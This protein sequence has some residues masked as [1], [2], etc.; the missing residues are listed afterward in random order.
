VLLYHG[1]VTV[2][3]CVEDC[4]VDHCLDISTTEPRSPASQ[5]VLIDILVEL[6]LL[7]VVVEYLLPPTNVWQR[8]MDNLVE[9]A[10]SLDGC[11]QR[12]LH[13]GRSDD[14]NVVGLLESIH[15]R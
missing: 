3:D 2:L 5:H 1:F 6:N 10:W 9:P 7:K 14:Y 13:I 11:I 8:H 4:L 12:L 15:L